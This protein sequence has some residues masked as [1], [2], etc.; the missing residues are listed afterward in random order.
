MHLRW[1]AALAG[2]A[3]V[4]AT[5][6]ARAADDRGGF[7]PTVVVQVKSV[8][9]WID[10]AKYALKEF[11]KVAPPG[12]ALPDPVQQLDQALGADWRK[13]IDTTRPLA[14]AARVSAANVNESPILLL[15]P[16]GDDQ[17]FLGLLKRHGMMVEKDGDLYHFTPPGMPLPVYLRFAHRYAYLSLRDDKPIKDKV[18]APDTIF[19]AGLQA[20][21]SAHV[22]IDRVAKELRDT[23]ASYIDQWKSSLPDVGGAF[24]PA[25]RTQI[26]AVTDFLKLL[27]QDGRSVSLG[28][29]LDRA[30]GELHL[31][32][33]LAGK[34]GTALARRFQ[35]VKVPTSL[36]AGVLGSNAV[37]G[38]QQTYPQFAGPPSFDVDAVTADLHRA[39][40]ERGVQISEEKL[41]PL[42]QAGLNAIKVNVSDMALSLRGPFAGGHYALVAGMH[43][44]DGH[45]L[46]AALKKHVPELGEKARDLVKFDVAKIDGVNV[47]EISVPG[48]LPPAVTK[49]FGNGPIRVAIRDDAVFLSFG[50]GTDL[51]REAVSAKPRVVPNFLVE[52]NGTKVADLVGQ[53]D[54]KTG[55]MLK[56]LLAGKLAGRV[57]LLRVTSTGGDALTITTSVNLTALLR[58]VPRAAGR[59]EPIPNP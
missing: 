46:E 17:A 13:A 10:L 7:A 35:D 37:A 51:L 2:L 5:A 57:E 3:L 43:I 36:V 31:D 58:L 55:A 11:G 56:K 24:G 28:L 48:E 45:A 52:A 15:I 21:L 39:L 26:A 6:P 18:P 22:Y 33:G 14:A 9:A 27:I 47:H 38:L 4:A 54:P 30:A 29:R 53:F 25:Q 19:T 23:A 16:T 32:L 40:T 50:G 41:R 59:K 1:L 42:V 49:I 34:P 12:T 44:H 20:E 8:D